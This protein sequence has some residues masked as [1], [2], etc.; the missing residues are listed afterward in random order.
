MII[1]DAVNIANSDLVSGI[2]NISQ[3]VSL[4]QATKSAT[5]AQLNTELINQNQHLENKLDEYTNG[6]LVKLTE[7]LKIVERQNEEIIALL[8]KK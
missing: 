4:Y 7:E 2:A 5:S 6:L 1:E 8:N 3:F